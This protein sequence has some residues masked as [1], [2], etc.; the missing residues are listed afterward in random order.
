M[1]YTINKTNYS[2]GSVQK[3]HRGKKEDNQKLHFKKKKKKIYKADY[4]AQIT[5]GSQLRQNGKERVQLHISD[6]AILQDY[7]AVVSS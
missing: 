2:L 1:S 6:N 4:N 3:Q 7:Y 5:S